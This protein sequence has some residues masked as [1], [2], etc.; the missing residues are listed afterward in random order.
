MPKVRHWRVKL[1][2]CFFVRQ[3]SVGT[4]SL[5][6]STSLVQTGDMTVGKDCP[7]QKEQLLM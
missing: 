6:S 7:P 5:L 2:F 4:P 3:E 1:R